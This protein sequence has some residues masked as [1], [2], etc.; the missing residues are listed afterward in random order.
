MN[1]ET[2]HP[3]V[4]RTGFSLILILAVSFSGDLKSML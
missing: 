2:R 3:A 4:V 1:D